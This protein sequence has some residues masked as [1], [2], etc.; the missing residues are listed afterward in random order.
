MDFPTGKGVV[1]AFDFDGVVCDSVGENA[2]TTWKALCTHWPHRASGE[3]DPDFLAKFVRCRP[4]IETGYQNIP[5]MLNLLDGATPEEILS[6]FDELT[7][8]AM[9]EHNLTNSRL[10]AMFG[11]ARDVWL[12]ADEES[13]LA[14]QGFYD[15]VP[16]A[17]NH[18]ADRAIIITTKQYRFAVELVKRAGINIG[19]DRVY[20]LE[21]LGTRGK[22]SVLEDLLSANP[23]AHAHFF[24]D[25]LATLNKMLDMEAVS[26]YLVDWGYNTQS[27]REEGAANPAI[28]L[29]T[30]S[31]FQALLESSR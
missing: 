2:L 24:E 28:Q 7:A 14:A 1:F 20:G 26:R 6:S 8:K 15:G 17:I 16:S 10:E 30:V 23:G 19:P 27:E 22:R 3:P 4:A 13:W 25:R 9:D 5:L 29:L 21:K 12:K 31:D 18:V 11:E